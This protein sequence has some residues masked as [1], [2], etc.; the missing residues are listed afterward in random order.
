MNLTAEDIKLANDFE[1]YTRYVETP[2]WHKFINCA[3]KVIGIFSG[4]QFGKDAMAARHYVLRTLSLH[5]V[6]DKNLNY[7]ICKN[8]H[9]WS[10][11]YFKALNGKCKICAN[12]VE[13]FFNQVRIIRCAS[14]NLPGQGGQPDNSVE[15]IETKNTQYP[16]LMKWMPSSLVT[17]KLT[18]RQPTLGIRDIWGGQDILFEFVGYNQSVQATAGTQRLS[19]WFSEEPPIAFWEE[20]QPRLLVADGD[21]VMALTPAN[22]MTYVY[23]QIFEKA[24]VYYRTPAICA[25]LGGAKEVEITDSDKS[26]AVFQ[27]A[28]DDNPTLK[29]E[30]V[31]RIFQDIDDPDVVA[32]R[33]Y[34]TFRQVSGRIFKS[35]DYRIHCI[36]KKKWF[37][38]GVNREWLHA[39]MIDYH[40][41]NRWACVWCSLSP[42]DELFVWD[43]YNPDP[44]RFTTWEISREVAA[45]SGNYRYSFDLIDPLSHITQNNTGK[46]TQDDLNRYFMELRNEG[47]GNGAY[48]RSWDSKSTRGRE[49]IRKRLKNAV[50]VGTPFNNK[51]LEK[52]EGFT[53]EVKLPTIWITDNCVN[54]LKSIKNWR[55]VEWANSN[56]ASI[57][58][59][60]EEAQQKWSHFC[61]ALEA[62]C[63][64]ANFRPRFNRRVGVDIPKEIRQERFKSRYFRG[65]NGAA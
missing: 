65:L 23:D 21:Q 52:E 43:E 18:V 29:P 30:A 54:I 55:L 51:V 47:L 15:I 57:K 25:F 37:P 16:E 50:R 14:E 33:R 32:I 61:T 34:G 5:P 28:T 42:D 41:T 60:R 17:K 46:S 59:P 4:N 27:A 63:K 22:R 39:R 26:I 56:D 2:L 64:E 38:N 35:F 6:P 3:A 36:S 19:C 11:R 10:L 45:I 31:K 13:M 62:I 53:R 20:Q 24:K 1:G 8:G 44:C 48:W 9:K 40:Q 49:E 12:P 58:D 7:L